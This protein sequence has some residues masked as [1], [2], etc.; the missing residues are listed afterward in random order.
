MNELFQQ[1]ALDALDHLDREEELL[2]KLN[3][4]VQQIRL[5]LL[6]KDTGLD[7]VLGARQTELV[8]EQQTVIQARA[9][10]RK[11]IACKLVISEDDATIGAL[12]NRCVE[13]TATALRQRCNRL[14]SKAM[15]LHTTLIANGNLAFQLWELLER[16]F[17]TLGGDQPAPQL[18]ER[19]GQRRAA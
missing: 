16:V 1:L 6:S 9:K 15:E 13:A 10:L 4:I 18:Y 19:N 2:D 8:A 7:A 3:V 5:E 12:S 17:R 11:R 14:Q